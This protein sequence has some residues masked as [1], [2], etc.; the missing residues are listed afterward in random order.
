VAILLVFGTGDGGSTPLGT[1]LNFKGNFMENILVVGANTRPVACSLKKI[2]YEVYSADYFG[3]QDLKACVTKNRSFLSQKP[4]VSCGFFSQKFDSEQL[5]DLASEFID[6]ADYIVYNSGASPLKFPKKKLI[7]NRETNTIEN[8]YKLYKHLL[9]RSDGVFKLPETYLVNNLQDALGIADDSDAENFILKPVEGSGG[10]GI[11][12]INDI[13][14]DYEIHEAILQ[15]IIDG[16]DVSASV[17]SNGDEANTILT[18]EQLIGNS[19]LGQNES[20][21]YCGNVAPFI[22]N[23]CHE[24]HPATKHF[25]EVAQQLIKDLGLIGSNGVDM[26]IK[27]GEIYVIEINPRLQG[28]FEVAEA[29]LGINMA[30]AHIMACNGELMNT[31]VPKKFSIKLVVYAQR[32]SMVGD[33]SMGCVH[34][35]PAR[36]VIIEEGEPVATVLTSDMVLEN[37]IQSA[38]RI[39]NDIYHNLTPTRE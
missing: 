1:I 25:D 3:C 24:T 2:G 29:A 34:D 37:S 14:P 17:L 8:K 11:K 21:G 19:W 26:I 28:T 10:L 18:T 12:N 33:L 15:E 7:G 5:H 39:V 32:R 6:L 22:K 4:F 16:Y 35:I 20:Y 38:G 13:D 36:N 31:T 23:P 30:K 9:K 27:D